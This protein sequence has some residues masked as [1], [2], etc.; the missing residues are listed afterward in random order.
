MAMGKTYR[1]IFK[2][3]KALHKYV[4][5]IFLFYF[6]LMGIS[7]I[8]LNH[9]SLIRRLSVPM[10]LVPESYVYSNWNRMA[11]REAVFSA[12]DHNTLYVGGKTGVW[13]SRDGG[14]SFTQLENGFPVSPYDRDT[15]CLLLTDSGGS[16]N[17]YAGT[18]IGLYRYDF[19]LQ[20]W[21]KADDG[22]LDNAEI[23]DLVRTDNRILVFTP[24]A[25]F[26]LTMSEKNPVLRRM[27][28]KSRAAPT[29]RAPLFRFLLKLHDGSVL[30]LPGKLF[31]DIIGLTLIFLA[32]SAIYIWYIPWHKKRFK[33]QRAKPRFIKF[34]HKYHLKLGIYGAFSLGIIALTGMFVRP[35]LL[36]AIIRYSVPAAL[37][38]DS[39]PVGEWQTKITR[40]V[41]FPENDTL[42]LATRNGFFRGPVDFSQPFEPAP[43]NVP[44][45]G[46]GVSVLENLSRHRLL[47]GSFSGLYIWDDKSG[48][49][50]DVQG[51]P[52]NHRGRGR[53]ETGMAVGAAVRNGELRYWADYHSGLKSTHQAGPTIAMP[54]RIVKNG[55]ISLWHFLFEVH[56]GRIFRDWLGEYTWLIVPVGGL[57]LLLNVL[58]GSYDWFYRRVLVRLNAPS[59]PRKG[60]D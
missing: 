43:I 5:L 25:C 59:L 56:N 23:V 46:M 12:K 39:R 7:G 9:P 27:P 20:R 53:A 4:G 8:L 50:T 14:K 60:K 35:P 6:L 17:L 22:T 18:R 26:G 16:P 29:L 3:S 19:N 45:H 28:L 38:N 33:K 52:V 31:V 37:L 36:I 48:L 10:T 55:R 32:V 47:I 13:E 41:Y 57:L 58:S 42:F 24:F 1:N 11:F 30:G 54:D 15:R 44:V 51:R 40:A 2:I 21:Q 34:F 49:A